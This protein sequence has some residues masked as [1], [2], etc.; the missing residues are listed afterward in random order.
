M[1]GLARVR[2]IASAALTDTVIS[3]AHDTHE[4]TFTVDRADGEYTLLVAGGDPSYPTHFEFEVQGEGHPSVSADLPVGAVHVVA[5]PVTVP[6]G[7]LAL[8]FHDG[9][10]LSSRGGSL[11]WVALD[12]QAASPDLYAAAAAQWARQSRAQTATAAKAQQED[13]AR[14]RARAAG[15]ARCRPVSLPRTTPGRQV[16]PL[17]GTW[18]FLP[19]QEREPGKDPRDRKVGDGNWHGLDVTQ[20]WT[21]MW[22]WIY[23][24]GEGTSD[25]WVQQEQARLATLSFDP[26]QTH[27]GWYRQWITIPKTYDKKRLALQ[28][29]GVAMTCEV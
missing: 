18:L 27:A 25:L 13:A 8:R 12:A 7:K 4:A 2:G 14:R 24:P 28:F 19:D 3:V 9:T 23:G 6:G 11:A 16:V 10:P 15:R 20:F 22:W 29:D 21:P 17:D 5:R 26:A 1:T